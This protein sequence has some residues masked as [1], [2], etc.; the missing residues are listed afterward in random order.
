MVRMPWKT[1][2]WP[3]LPQLWYRGSWAGLAAAVGFTCGLNLALIATFGWTEWIGPAVRTF[4]WLCV[5]GV[6]LAAVVVSARQ[7]QLEPSAEEAD[8]AKDLFQQAQGE[9]LKGNWYEAELALNRLLRRNGHDLEARLMLASLFRHSGRVAEAG[10]QLRR[11]ERCD[12]SEKWQVEIES[13]WSWLKEMAQETAEE[14]TT[15]SSEKDNPAE[16]DL[17]DAA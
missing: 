17:A 10:D 1:W 7:R 13:E 5:G 11:L 4:G 16:A 15:Q 12:G 8:S 9:Y 3:G 6:W 14:Q 2:L